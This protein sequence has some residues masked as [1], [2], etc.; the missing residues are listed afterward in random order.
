MR[1]LQH[2]VQQ[3][4]RVVSRDM[5]RQAIW[6]EG[7]AQGPRPQARS[8]DQVVRRLR[9]LLASLGLEDNLKSLRGLGYRL[10]ADPAPRAATAKP[11]NR[12]V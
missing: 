7:F 5:L 3:S 4:G 9:Q 2:L 11:R 12:Q 1:L 10:D 8:V 6:P